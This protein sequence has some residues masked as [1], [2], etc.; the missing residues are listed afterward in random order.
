LETDR[1]AIARYV[2]AGEALLE[3]LPPKARR[4]VQEQRL[5]DQVNERCR[6][7]RGVFMRHHAGDVYS[8]LT[9]GHSRHHRLSELV[10]AAAE[11]FPGVVPTRAQIETER[12]CVQAHKEGREI[13][14]GIFFSALLRSPRAGAH[15]ADAMLLPT[16]RARRLVDELRS[17]DA[18]DLG[19]VLVERHGC[20][21]YLTIHN[22]RCLNA[23][24]DALIADMETAVDLALLDDRV[25]V[26]VLRGGV[27][28]H[29]RYAGRRVFSAGINLSDLHGG[30]ISFVDFFLARELGYVR[31]LAHGLLAN[32]AEDA[33]SLRTI[34][35]PWIGAVDSFALGGGMQLLLVLDK[36][37]AEQDAYFTLPAAQEGIVPGA[38]NLRLGRATGSRLAR[39]IILS[40]R[41]IFATD[42]EA[43]ALCDV[44]V[45]SAHV[46]AA[47][48]EAVEELDTP[49]VIANRRM[50]QLVEEPP[51]LF[52]EYMA[53]FAL[54]Q[55]TRLYSADVLEKIGRW[56]R[57]REPTS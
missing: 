44:V 3:A 21:A 35:K 43:R 27:M 52:R 30:R 40:G 48:E 5:A 28:A 15:I 31:K 7:L 23:E 38:A 41:K 42:P 33:L 55:A 51:E 22:P 4:A 24:D 20:A 37:I 2:A 49:A 12:T 13:D 57:A 17:R 26:G 45:P 25:R 50:L 39:R 34:Q 46:E 18:V 9:D 47:V 32:P 19:S 6:R 1:V 29:P 11:R 53:E 16:Q 54:V 8:I 14:Q 56:S 10:F 36:V